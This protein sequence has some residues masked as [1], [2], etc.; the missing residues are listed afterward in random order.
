MYVAV[1]ASESVGYGA[2]DPRNDAWPVVFARAALPPG[3][4]FVNLGIPGATVARALQDELP[5]ASALEPAPTLAT[6]W[7]NVNDLIALVPP[8]AYEADL[9]RL[10]GSLRRGGATRVLV[11]NTPPLDRLP[12]YLACRPNPP[13]GSPPCRYPV[14][15]LVPP[16]L[17][18]ARVAEYNA[19]IARVAAGSGAELVDL[20]AAALGARAEGREPAYYGP[21]GF[22]PST[23]GHRAVAEA[24]AAVLRRTLR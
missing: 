16:S 12:V 19:A 5:R 3:T 11:A 8:A 23:A 13:P 7:L 24:F 1:G 17:L 10:V 4:A 2:S 21:D 18:V 22:H 14:L 6:V 9:A 20:H 15:S